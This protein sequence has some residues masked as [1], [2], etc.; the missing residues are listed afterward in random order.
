M[1]AHVSRKSG[2]AL[3]EFMAEVNSLPASELGVCPS[4]QCGNVGSRQSIS[5]LYSRL[6]P[7]L[8]SYLRYLGMN[9]DQAEDVIQDS[10]LRLIRC[11]FEHSEERDIRAWIFCVAR[12]LSMDVHRAQRRWSPSNGDNPR[13]AIRERIDPAPGPEQLVLLGER[14]S[15]LEHSFAQ[16]TPKQRRCVLLRVEGFRYRE[17]AITLGVSLQRVGELMQRSIALLEAD[18]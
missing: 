9:T 17:I 3:H 2:G 7:S 13:S 1:V 10:F 4:E 6:R 11:R 16:L 12:N 8:H 18:T 15:R 5:E 14:M